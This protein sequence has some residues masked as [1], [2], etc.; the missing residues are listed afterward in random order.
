METQRAAQSV[1]AELLRVALE[2]QGSTESVEARSRS[3]IIRFKEGTKDG[4]KLFFFPATDG[5]AGYF[6]FLAPY[7][8]RSVSFYG[9][10]AP[11][12]EREQAPYRA[13]EEIAEH[14]IREIRAIQPKGP[15]YLGGFCM[16]GLPS[17]EVARR[18]RRAGE[19]VALLVQLMPVFRR[20]W[21]DLSGVEAIQ[22][23][24]IE[25]HVFIFNRWFKMD[26]E[27]PMEEIRALPQ[28]E[29]FAFVTRYVA[30]AGFLQSNA[31]QELFN[32]RLQMY[33]AGLEA[34]LR[35]QPETDHSGVIDVVLLSAPGLDDDE[36]DM[37]TAYTSH[38]RA[39]APEQIRCVKKRADSAAVFDGA[40][41]DLDIIGQALASYFE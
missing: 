16:G 31:E 22:F 21:R 18:L 39:I 17:Y 3:N 2:K 14:N 35:Y 13:V 37:N 12:Y 40:Q 26:I 27:L 30:E 5:G 15:Y 20:K 8:P 6:R 29:R 7:L 41:P 10:Q 4:P 25:D 11:G 34:M 32:H 28:E 36:L 33:E 38:L 19:E 23:R 1:R 24:A 9:C